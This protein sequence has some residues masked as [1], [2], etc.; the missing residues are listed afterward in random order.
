MMLQQW[1]L[2]SA[3]YGAYRALL[4]GFGR[5]RT[6]PEAVP[7]SSGPSIIQRSD[8]VSMGQEGC[9]TPKAE[10][11]EG[12]LDAL[13]E[14]TAAEA[15][16][17]APAPAQGSEREAHSYVNLANIPATAKYSFEGESRRGVRSPC[18][19]A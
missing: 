14:A 3:T 4:R 11:P 8:S 19:T 5:K 17:S 6:D 7:D 15:I 13:V 18:P 9:Q 2:N 1:S 10:C 16:P 12:S